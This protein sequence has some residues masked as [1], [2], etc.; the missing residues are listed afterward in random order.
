MLLVPVYMSAGN[1]K[2]T[3]SYKTAKNVKTPAAELSSRNQNLLA[4]YSAEVETAADKIISGSPSPAAR[5]QALVW[6]AEAIPVMQSSLLTK[7]P[8]LRRSIPGRS[9]FK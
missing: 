2:K 4:L 5:R 7:T 8:L 1:T 3:S 6:K 9:F